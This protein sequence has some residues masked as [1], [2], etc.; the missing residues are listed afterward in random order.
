MPITQSAKKA[1]R[2]SKRKRIFN[3]RRKEAISEA[4]KEIKKLVAE[5]KITEAKAM[6]PS[7]YK[8]LD[9]AAKTGYIKKNNA[10]RKKSRISALIKKAA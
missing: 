6:L 8:A 9:K 2:G 5:K 7:A 3:V 10:S 4:I 1:L